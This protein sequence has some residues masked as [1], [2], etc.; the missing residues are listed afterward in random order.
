MADIFD[1]TGEK[2]SSAE[3]RLF[4]VN[5]SDVPIKYVPTYGFQK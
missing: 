4:P 5:I 1:L 2:S 3:V